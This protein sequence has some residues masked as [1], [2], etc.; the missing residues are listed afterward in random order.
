MPKRF[1][2]AGENTINCTTTIQSTVNWNAPQMMNC[3]GEP[4][5]MKQK[6]LNPS[7]KN[8]ERKENQRDMRCMISFHYM[9]PHPINAIQHTQVPRINQLNPWVER[10]L[11]L[12]MH[13]GTGTVASMLRL[14]AP[15]ISIN[16][17]ND[18]KIRYR[19]AVMAV[20]PARKITKSIQRSQAQ[21]RFHMR[22]RIWRCEEGGNRTSSK[23]GSSTEEMSDENESRPTVE[24]RVDALGMG[25]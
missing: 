12:A 17:L 11:K 7:P 20:K 1:R 15:R 10:A 6:N 3:K 2:I 23:S 13:C 5:K 21:K 4:V 25:R 8:Y 19:M 18:P 24:Y 22:P 14:T 16:T 9:L